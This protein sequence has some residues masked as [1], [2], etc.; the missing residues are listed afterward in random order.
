MKSIR[1]IQKFHFLIDCSRLKQKEGILKLK[2]FIGI[3][4]Y[5]Y[6]DNTLFVTKSTYIN[7]ILLSGG[8][9]ILIP[10][11]SDLTECKNII[12]KLDGLLLPGG[13]DIS[14]RLYGEEPQKAAGMSIYNLDLYE[15][16]LIHEAKKSKKP[17]LAICRGIQI[18]NVAL[19]GTLYQDIDA[20]KAATLCHNQSINVRDE[21]TH[22]VSLILDSVLYHIYQQDKIYVNSYHHQAVKD[23]AKDL[24]PTAYSMDHILEA[25]ESKDG[26]IIGVQ[27]HPETLISTDDNSKKL[28]RYFVE[29]CQAK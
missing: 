1:L 26:R 18:L 4:A 15:I 9:P 7:A 6:L 24:L 14:P 3:T 2:P 13:I 22:S 5:N 29:L 17:I 16:E 19:G 28:F 11:T 23:L 27:W 12:G 10:Y 20:Q 25:C 8:I 21:M